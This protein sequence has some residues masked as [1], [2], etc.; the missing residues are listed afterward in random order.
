M[1]LEHLK[2][3]V[4]HL[5]GLI[6]LT[7]SDIE[8][9]KQAKHTLIFERTK[10]KSKLIKSF[11]NQKSLVDGELKKLASNGSLNFSS[12]EEQFLEEL[13][14]KLFKL[15]DLNREYARF[16]LGVSEFYNSLLERVVPTEMSG[17]N[18]V[19][20]SNSYLHLKA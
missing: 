16:V 17:Y 7:E 15:K 4:S 12:D 14:D 11:E 8:D 9:I 18:K 2:L 1:L 10:E 20:S 3:A 19:V 6:G 5:N 13:K